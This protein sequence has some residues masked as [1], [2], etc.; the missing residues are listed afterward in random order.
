MTGPYFGDL[1]LIQANQAQTVPDNST[2]PVFGVV[3]GSLRY[4]LADNL[5]YFY[6]GTIW[7][8]LAAGSFAGGSLT[9]TSLTVDNL[10]V[11]DLTYINGTVVD[12]GEQYI[13]LNANVTG[14]PSLNAGLEVNRG[15]SPLAEMIWNEGTQ[16]WQ[17]GVAGNMHNVLQIASEVPFSNTNTG[18]Q[19]TNI[20][21]AIVETYIPYQIIS[22]NMTIPDG[23]YHIHRNP[24]IAFGVTVTILGSGELF[25][26]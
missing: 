23:R 21:D 15:T 12:V 17:V 4:S 18:L 10:T 6:N 25:A 19:A 5:L 2:L 22:N 3:S 20:Q 16:Q 1:P 24:T 26:L 9:L 14:T 8:A 13:T 7:Q 11:N